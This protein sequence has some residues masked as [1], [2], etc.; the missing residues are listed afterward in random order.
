M[1]LIGWIVRQLL[2]PVVGL[3]ERYLDNEADRDRLRHGT[4]RIIYQ[5]DTTL[6]MAR[7]THMLGRLPLFCAELAGA[8]YF[9]AILIDSTYPLDW[10]TPLELPQWFKPHFHIAMASIFG[11]AT[12]DR[13]L[14][15]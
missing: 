15:R 9:S 6:R 11:I 13:W 8:A 12:V 3:G 10:L 1:S 14:G 4:D 5:S 2:K 7:L